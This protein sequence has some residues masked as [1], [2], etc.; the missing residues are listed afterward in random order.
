MLSA[1]VFLR[2]LE[3]FMFLGNEIHYPVFSGILGRE[4]I[5]MN[6]QCN[7]GTQTFL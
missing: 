1:V 2:S 3:A 7:I 6:K 5:G 4:I